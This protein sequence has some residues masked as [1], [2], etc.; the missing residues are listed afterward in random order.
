M[1]NFQNVR[2]FEVHSKGDE[3]VAAISEYGYQLLEASRSKYYNRQN[4]VFLSK[5]STTPFETL[6]RSR[7]RYLLVQKFNQRQMLQSKPILHAFRKFALTQMAS[8]LHKEDVALLAGHKIVGS[9]AFKFYVGKNREKPTPQFEERIA[10]AY[11][12]SPLMNLRFT[13]VVPK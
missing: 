10:R 8:T 13:S 6:I 4:V 3:Y 1:S 11:S 9:T 2:L 5:D 7:M 12:Q